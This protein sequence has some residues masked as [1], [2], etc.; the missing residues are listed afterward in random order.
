M[1]AVSDDDDRPDAKVYNIR[2]HVLR[3]AAKRV[4][5]VQPSPP[6][7]MWEE[8]IEV[9][10]ADGTVYTTVYNGECVT[11][12]WDEPDGRAATSFSIRTGE[13]WIG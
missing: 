13:I 2:D 10:D 4:T 1:D 7:G 8:L 5:V 12:A 11:V 9:L 3:K 6:C